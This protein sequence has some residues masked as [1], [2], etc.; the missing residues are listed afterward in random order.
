MSN[1]VATFALTMAAQHNPR[2][3]TISVMAVPW[4]KDMEALVTFA[5]AFLKV[6]M[7]LVVFFVCFFENR[8]SNR[9]GGHSRIQRPTYAQSV[10]NFAWGL[11]ILSV[12]QTRGIFTYRM[13][14]VSRVD[15]LISRTSHTVSVAVVKHA[16]F[17]V[18]V[19]M[20][21][22]AGLSLR[23]HLLRMYHFLGWLSDG[24]AAHPLIRV[25]LLRNY[26]LSTRRR[27]RILC[28]HCIVCQHQ[29]EKKVHSAPVSKKCNCGSN[30]QEERF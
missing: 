5:A 27:H 29:L 13:N 23:M 14:L 26:G 3:P 1:P 16:Y 9:G 19:A 2:H 10:G 25:H 4:Y 20:L 8:F 24:G 11:M 30:R 28:N 18:L 12:V 21:S 7:I 17:Q 6:A 22:G 15:A